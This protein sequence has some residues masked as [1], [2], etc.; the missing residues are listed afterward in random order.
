ME[1]KKVRFY[2]LVAICSVFISG[3]SCLSQDEPSADKYNVL[4]F[5]VDDM[6]DYAGYLKSYG[7][8]VYTPNI[9]RLARAGVS[10]EKAYATAPI[11]SPARAGLI[12][13]QYQQRWGNYSLG[14][15]GHGLPDTAPTIPIFLKGLGYATKKVGKNHKISKDNAIEFMKS[16]FNV[17][18]EED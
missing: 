1:F 2:S 15:G 7:G 14:Q 8:E 4:I 16:T 13:G 17:T 9:D 11:C 5:T 10:F 6:R 3:Q 18:V 12:S